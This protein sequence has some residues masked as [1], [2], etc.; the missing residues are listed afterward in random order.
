MYKHLYSCH[1]NMLIKL[2]LPPVSPL[3]IEMTRTRSTPQSKVAILQASSPDM[4]PDLPQHLL[5]VYQNSFRT[6]GLI[7]P[8]INTSRAAQTFLQTSAPASP[9]YTGKTGIHNLRDKTDLMMNARIT[10]RVK[11]KAKGFAATAMVVLLPQ[12]RSW[13]PVLPPR[14]LKLPSSDMTHHMHLQTENCAENKPSFSGFPYNS[15]AA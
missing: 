5:K 3:K 14:L 1:V 9:T 11:L 2:T 10:L 6:S 4:P 13:S 8:W 15:S 12:P 7:P